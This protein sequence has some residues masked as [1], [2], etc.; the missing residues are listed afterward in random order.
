MENVN[1]SFKFISSSYI[2]NLL[3]IVVKLKNKNSGISQKA[4]NSAAKLQIQSTQRE[5]QPTRSLF[6][7]RG[8]GLPFVTGDDTS[9]NFCARYNGNVLCILVH[10]I[11]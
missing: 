6:D 9:G 3:E 10:F 5:H 2:K 4:A 11:L 1:F 8:H 7:S